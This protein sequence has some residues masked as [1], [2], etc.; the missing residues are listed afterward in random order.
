MCLKSSC[1]LLLSTSMNKLMVWWFLGC[2]QVDLGLLLGIS[3][4]I[5]LFLLGL[6]WFFNSKKI[7]R[8]IFLS[9]FF[10]LFLISFLLSCPVD[11]QKF[12]FLF[13]TL[14][15]FFAND[16][17]ERLLH[18]CLGHLYIELPLKLSFV[19]WQCFLNEFE[20]LLDLVCLLASI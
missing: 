10:M 8:F 14:N 19:I 1:T 7:F 2:S 9:K 13:N 15:C 17:F 11:C 12:K 18:S 6:S 20:N 5:Q 3:K 4:D 16:C